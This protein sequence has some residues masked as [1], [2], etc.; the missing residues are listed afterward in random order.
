MQE[1]LLLQTLFPESPLRA[2]NK[3]DPRQHPL[4]RKNQKNKKALESVI[5]I[6]MDTEDDLE[7]MSP[8]GEEARSKQKRRK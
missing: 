6:D 8:M 4:I 5:E 2:E 1:C 3:G 7:E